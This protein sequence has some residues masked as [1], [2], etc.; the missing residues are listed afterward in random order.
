[1]HVIPQIQKAVH[2]VYSTDLS[3]PPEWAEQQRHQ[4]LDEEAD[5]ISEMVLSTATTLNQQAIAQWHRRHPHQRLDSATTEALSKQAYLAAMRQVL[6]TELY[7]LIPSLEDS[8]Q[9]PDIDQPDPLINPRQLSWQQRW[10]QPP[11]RSDPNVEIEALIT[12]LWPDPQF[13]MV[14]RIKAGYLLAA[15]HEDGLRLPAHPEEPLTAE[16]ADLIYT[17]LRHDGLPA[18]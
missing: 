12:R 2:R 4:Y 7:E 15:L 10:T 16:L 1:M 11:Y 8:A 6:S 13:S 5:K 9:M 17:D 14:F 18:H 3:L